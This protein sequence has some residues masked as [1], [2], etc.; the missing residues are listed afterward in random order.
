[1]Q[2]TSKHP[3][4]RSFIII[5]SFRTYSIANYSPPSPTLPLSVRIQASDSPLNQT[6]F[7]NVAFNYNFYYICNTFMLVLFWSLWG[8]GEGGYCSAPPVLIHR[9]PRTEP[10]CFIWFTTRNYYS[11]L[12]VR[13]YIKHIYIYLLM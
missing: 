13:V 10:Y 2:H 4:I 3:C 12:R 9:L 5:T 6:N 7:S 1:M 11:L 8:G